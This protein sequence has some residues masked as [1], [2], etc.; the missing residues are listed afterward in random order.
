MI[1]HAQTR[2]K[3]SIS[4]IFTKILRI[5]HDHWGEL[6]YDRSHTRATGILESMGD[7]KVRTA[8]LSLNEQTRRIS[9]TVRLHV[10]K[11]LNTSL[12]SSFLRFQNNLLNTCTFIT[13]DSEN[14]IANLRTVLPVSEKD[15][16]F[17]VKALFDDTKSILEDERLNQILN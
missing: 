6:D 17:T 8:E 2:P 1:T 13:I 16:E 12:I 15:P 14:N 10:A 3:K 4:H 7:D 9:L 11:A 5:A